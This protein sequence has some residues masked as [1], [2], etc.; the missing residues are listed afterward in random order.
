VAVA[1]DGAE[2]AQGVGPSTTRVVGLVQQREL[3]DRRPPGR[4]LERRTRQVVR[5]DRRSRVRVPSRVLPRGPQAD[6][7]AGAEPTG[8]S[9]PLVR[10]GPGGGHGDQPGH[11]GRSVE[12]RLPRQPCIDHRVHPLDRQAAL[13]EVGGDDHLPPAAGSRRDRPVLLGR[14]ERSV[15]RVDRDLLTGRQAPEL[16]GR[17]ADLG[18]AGQEDQ[19]VAGLSGTHLSD[20]VGDRGGEVTRVGAWP[21]LDRDGVL[22]PSRL[23][24]RRVPEQVGHPS[25]VEG[26]GGDEDVQIRTQGAPRFEREGQR[27]VGLEVALVELVEEQH[28]RAGQRRIP[29]QPAEQDPLRDHLDARRPADQTLVPGHEPDRAPRLLPQLR[30]QTPCRSAGR[31]A[32]GF[33]QDQPSVR[34][35]ETG[36]EEVQRD[37]RRL[38]RSRRG[39]QDHQPTV[40]QRGSERGEH[41]LDRE[42][43][44]RT[45]TCHL[46]GR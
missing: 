41:L 39:L 6:R 32:P 44:R 8:S 33:E 10:R 20:A 19:D 2:L 18:C 9:C 14:R 28:A 36:F 37:H 16:A 26:G 25:A 21:M 4:D 5:A 30:S 46:G 27:E 13:R 22:P 38:A 29:L 43:G 1:V 34:A 17:A 31:H 45:S 40:G 12:P 11:P 42:V 7:Q 24:D 35:D 3:L 23:H 15:Q